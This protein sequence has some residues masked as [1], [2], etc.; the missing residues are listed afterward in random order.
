MPL[1]TIELVINIILYFLRIFSFEVL[2]YNVPFVISI[3]FFVI[4]CEY[5][6]VTKIDLRRILARALP[7]LFRKDGWD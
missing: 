7:G 4:N 5:A 3:R 2:I 1:H 6:L